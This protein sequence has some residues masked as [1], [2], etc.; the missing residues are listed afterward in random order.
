[1]PPAPIGDALVLTVSLA[2]DGIPWLGAA[3]AVH[4]AVD[5]T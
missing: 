4:S 5:V 3:P 2:I 1:V